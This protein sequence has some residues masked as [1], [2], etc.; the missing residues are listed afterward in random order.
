RLAA[1]RRECNKKAPRPQGESSQLDD[2]TG[3]RNM[4]EHMRG[5]EAV[6][7]I[8]KR[9]IEDGLR[10]V[11]LAVDSELGSREFR[12][13]LRYFACGA[14]VAEIFQLPAAIAPRAAVVEDPRPGGDPELAQRRNGGSIAFFRS[15]ELR[16][17]K[18]LK[19]FTGRQFRREPLPV[20]LLIEL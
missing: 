8:A 13:P 18:L 19:R 15:D 3:A 4:F 11:R 12:A 2:S 16:R 5:K 9:A 14:V 7:C 10:D 17:E 1:V 6:E 20:G